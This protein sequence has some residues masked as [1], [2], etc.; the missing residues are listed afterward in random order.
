V[1]CRALE[2]SANTD[3]SET[4]GKN[5][6]Y[7]PTV[8]ENVTPETTEAED[9]SM[10]IPQVATRSWNFGDNILLAPLNTTECKRTPANTAKLEPCDKIIA[11][12]SSWSPTGT[13]FTGIYDGEE[14]LLTA[15]V[16]KKRYDPHYLIGNY[17]QW[18]M[19]MAGAG[20]ENISESTTS[21]NVTTMTRAFNAPSSICPKGWRLPTGGILDT[22]DTT[23]INLVKK[24]YINTENDSIPSGG[25]PLYYVRAGDVRYYEGGIS[26]TGGY[27]EYFTSTAGTSIR[28]AY[29]LWVRGVGFAFTDNYFRNQGRSI[30]CL[31]R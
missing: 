6:K 7:P 12:D 1:W 29:S 11:V 13:T 31:V 4:W 15:D 30:R 20:G 2:I 25:A 22:G 16:A 10:I 24:Y 19:A 3:V 17:Y 21:G 26:G 14:T 8:T 18:N 28:N 27:A 23:F 5:S 9:P